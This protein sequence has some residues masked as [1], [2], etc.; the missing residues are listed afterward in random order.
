MKKVTEC[1]RELSGSKKLT[2][3]FAENLT[4]SH[5]SLD[6]NQVISSAIQSSCNNYENKAT[7]SRPI[8]KRR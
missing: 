5:H 4:I 6:S 3:I 8:L 1:R 2:S 7:V